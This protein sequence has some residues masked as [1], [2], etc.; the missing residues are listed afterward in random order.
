MAKK[1]RSN[2]VDRRS[3]ITGVATAGAAAV[4]A[5]PGSASAAQGSPKLAPPSPFEIAAETAAQVQFAPNDRYHVRNPGSDYM[6]DVIKS[7]PFDYIA[8]IPGNTFRGL[9][10]SLVNYGGNKKPELL[11]VAH[12]EVSGA[13]AHGYAKIAGK[14]MA[15]MVHNTVGLQ[16]ASMALYDAWADRVP[17]MVI[18]GNGDFRC[19]EASRLG[20]L[21]TLRIRTLPLW[22]AAS[23]NTTIS[24]P[25]LG[26]FVESFARA[27][28]LSMTLLIVEPS[29]SQVADGSLR[30]E[31]AKRS[32]R[33][34]NTYRSGRP[35]ASATAGFR[36]GEDAGC[37]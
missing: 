31:P 18:V 35:R 15:L 19:D 11:S 14:P 27:Y 22:C 36:R 30:E 37:G 28:S 26:H 2:G 8:A 9:H 34:P 23:S 3:F 32:R 21:G 7:F 25:S 20:R 12:E 6:V 4:V 13:M 5:K 33:S 29:S 16:H 24:Q 1:P 17:M 10:E